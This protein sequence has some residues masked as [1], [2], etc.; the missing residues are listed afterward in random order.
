MSTLTTIFIVLGSVAAVIV[1]SLLAAF[2]PPFM[3]AVK[4][5]G[6]SVLYIIAAVFFVAALPFIGIYMTIRRVKGN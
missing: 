4:V 3:K 5:V 1:L 2:V 6:K